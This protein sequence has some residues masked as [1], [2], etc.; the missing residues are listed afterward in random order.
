MT[1]TLVTVQSRPQTVTHPSTNRAVSINDIDQ[2]KRAY[3]YITP[4][5]AT[6]YNKYR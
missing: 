2:S 3:H 6:V 5:P 1:G 4:P